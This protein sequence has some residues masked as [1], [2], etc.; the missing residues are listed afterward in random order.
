MAFVMDFLKFVVSRATLSY[1]IRLLT[2]VE[3]KVDVLLHFKL[4]FRG[5]TYW[6]VLYSSS[7]VDF[8]CF[9]GFWLFLFYLLVVVFLV[10]FL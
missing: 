6:R 4:S 2:F 3:S 10:F 7:I 8:G 9:L 5:C 1:L